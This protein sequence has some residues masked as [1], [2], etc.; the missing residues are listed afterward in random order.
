MSWQERILPVRKLIAGPS[1]TSQVTGTKPGE[2]Y[3]A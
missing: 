2:I 1:I 3:Y